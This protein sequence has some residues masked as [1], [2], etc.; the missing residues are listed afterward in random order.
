[1]GRGELEGLA[2]TFAATLDDGR[3]SM[4]QLQGFLMRYKDNP[5][6]AA[7]EATTIDSL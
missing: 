3:Y 1:M 5:R 7:K 6:Q 4:A 2:A